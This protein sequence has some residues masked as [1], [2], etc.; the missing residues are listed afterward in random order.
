[1][2]LVNVE[3]L[4]GS[5]R[6]GTCSEC[7]AGFSE[8]NHMKKITF[9]NDQVTYTI[10]LCGKCYEELFRTIYYQDRCNMRL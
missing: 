4:K 6:H 3:E 5:D 10:F 8:I 1:M 7:G 9:G 2:R